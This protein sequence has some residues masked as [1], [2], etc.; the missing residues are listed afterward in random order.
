MRF[1]AVEINSSFY[2]PHQ[3]GAYARWAASVPAGFRFS[4]KL[5]KAIAHEQSLRDC[6]PLGCLLVQL[7]PSL[8]FDAPTAQGFLAA[9]RQRLALRLQRAADSGRQVAEGAAVDN[10]LYV[11]QALA[12]PAGVQPG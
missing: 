2:R 8:A 10:A 12:R 9:L 6:A 3:A 5:P 1:N 11:T 7:P 4:V